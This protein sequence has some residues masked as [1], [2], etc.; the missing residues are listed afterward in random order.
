[1]HIFCTD[2]PQ[3]YQAVLSCPQL[4]LYDFMFAVIDYIAGGW[5]RMDHRVI[6]MFSNLFYCKMLFIVELITML[7]QYFFLEFASIAEKN[8]YFCMVLHIRIFF[9][10][11]RAHS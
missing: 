1:M 5:A 8:A 4:P 11:V 10:S 3:Q 2:Q 7:S 6:F 9:F